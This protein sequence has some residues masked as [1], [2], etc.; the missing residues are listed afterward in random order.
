MQL[1]FRLHAKSLFVVVTILI[2]AA[3]PGCSSPTSHNTKQTD[4]SPAARN[5]A[6]VPL[7]RSSGIRTSFGVQSSG[8]SKDY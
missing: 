3:F 6:P 2:L 8:V 4:S 1:H 7:R 5:T